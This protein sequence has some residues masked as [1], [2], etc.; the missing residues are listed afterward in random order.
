MNT[1]EF[2]EIV[3]ALVPFGWLSRAIDALEERMERDGGH[4]WAHIVRVMRNAQRISAQEDAD[5]EVVA[6]AV[7][8]HDAVNLPKD[9]PER[10]QA[11]ALSAEFASRVLAHD[12]ETDRLERVQAAIREHSYSS[13][14]V[15][16]S[17]EARVVCD[18]DRLEAIGA[19]GIARAFYVS[20]MLG[21]SI[22]HMSDPWGESRDLDDG[23]YGIDHFFEKLL[24]VADTMR[25]EV[26]KSMARERHDYLVGFLF[27][28]GREIGIPYGGD[29]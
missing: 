4:D 1:A 28:F 11:S 26:G 29:T 10:S 19:I 20:G 25:T 12:F 18:A 13:G 7:L 16:E 9:H 6:A 21:R 15:P 2:H 17:I 23:E 27:E 3:A 24:G 5:W 8:F 22:A 14:L